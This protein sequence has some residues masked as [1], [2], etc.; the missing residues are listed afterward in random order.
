MRIRVVAMARQIT[1]PRW[2]RVTELVCLLDCVR[3]RLTPKSTPEEYV[4]GKRCP[5]EIGHM[6]EDVKELTIGDE[7]VVV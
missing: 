2:R 5:A 6:N 1:I 4:C 7:L 3:T